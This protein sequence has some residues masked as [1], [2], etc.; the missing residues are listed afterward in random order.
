M[1]LLVNLYSARAVSQSRDIQ[2]SSRWINE[3]VCLSF[4]EVLWHEVVTGQMLN[5]ISGSSLIVKAK[6]G[7][8]CRL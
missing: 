5:K 4:D 3:A 7:Q 2:F 1:S 6:H 8:Q